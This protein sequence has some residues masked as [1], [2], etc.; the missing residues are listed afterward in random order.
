M[1]ETQQALLTKARQ[2]L[3][4]AILLQRESHHGFAASRAYYAMFYAVQALLDAE[5]LTF[6]SHS[7][8]ISAFGQHFAK[9]GRLD[10]RF[11]RFLLEASE[12]REEGDYGVPG[13]VSASK[14]EEHL[15]QAEEFLRHAEALLSKG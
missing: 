10:P 13:E 4:A 8:T 7:A 3:E 15:R 12:S 14:A 9:T 11:H 1:T 5:G 6:S 2:S